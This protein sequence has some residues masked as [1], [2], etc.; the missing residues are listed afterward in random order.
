M[1]AVLRNF[2]DKFS[3]ENERT[4]Q[5][6]HTNILCNYKNKQIMKSKHSIFSSYGSKQMYNLK[7]RFKSNVMKLYT[8]VMISERSKEDSNLPAC[9]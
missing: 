2:N 8:Y 7:F 1:F 9:R 4:I 3:D 6:S 5:R